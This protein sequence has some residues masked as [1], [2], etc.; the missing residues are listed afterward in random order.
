MKTTK[1]LGLLV[2]LFIS[3]I[4]ITGCVERELVINTNPQGAKILL[5]DEEIGTTPVAV[6]FKWYGDYRVHISKKGFETIKTHQELKRP[7]H[8]YFPLDFF[9]EIIYPGKI[10]DNYEWRFD[11]VPYQPIDRDTLIKKATTMHDTVNEDNQILLEK[12]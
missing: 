11:L 9:A 3:S 1:N 2:T 10:Q 4:F 12:K 7:A 5:N 6:P 8:D